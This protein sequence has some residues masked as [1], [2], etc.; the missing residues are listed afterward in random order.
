MLHQRQ[1]LQAGASLRN[2]TGQQTA[3]EIGGRNALAGIAARGSDPR[4]GVERH[5][6]HP[7]AR[8]ADRSAPAVRH[9]DAGQY[10]KPLDN[11]S[12]NAS[13]RFGVAILIVRDRRSEPVRCA[14]APE[15]D[16]PIR[17]PCQVIDRE[18]L[19]R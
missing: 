11:R 7:V 8:H 17:R 12:L 6:R 1:R 14:A 19:R 16:P 4:L 10:R 5:G 2:Q 13:V 18:A 3:G 9:L 15:Q